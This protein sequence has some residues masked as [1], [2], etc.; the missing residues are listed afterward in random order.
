[1][2]NRQVMT[3]LAATISASF[4]AL[5]LLL[6][7]AARPVTPEHLLA[8]VHGPIPVLAQPGGAPLAR[9][10]ATTPFGSA[11][12]LSVTR[13]SGHWLRVSTGDLQIGRDGW[14]DGDSPAI[15]IS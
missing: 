5:S 9:L 3:P 4:S 12:V 2:L 11:R 13:R 6:H 8:E 7:P 10:G 15:T 1:M 14:I